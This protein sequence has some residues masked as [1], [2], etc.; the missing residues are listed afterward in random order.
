MRL[1]QALL[2]CLAF[3]F[4]P[5]IALTADPRAGRPASSPEAQAAYQDIQRTL[6]LVPTFL[7]RYP[8]EAIAAAWQE[9]K[10]LQLNPRTALSGRYKELIGLGVSA[11]I[12][13]KF[14]VHFH[15][16]AARLNGA[17]DQEVREA[18]AQASL[19]RQW[20]T[21][22]NGLQIDEA[23]FRDEMRQAFEHTRRAMQ[24]KTAPPPETRITDAQSA[25]D[26]MKRTLGVVPTFFRRFP[27]AAIASAWQAYKA[28]EM[29]PRTALSGKHKELIGLAVSAQVPCKFCTHFHTEAARMNGATDAE[30]GEAVA[31]AGLTRKWSTFLNGIEMDESTFKREVAQIMAHVQRGMRTAAAPR[32]ADLR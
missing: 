26:D 11:Q 24:Q 13:C 30:V 14:C 22:V 4:V 9:M 32:G 19:T 8:Q 2:V 3:L 31:M 25:Y 16:R 7:Q 6:G 29:N 12:P 21:I 23:Q 27:Q 18:L 5:A 10:D 1:R 20:S 28:V 15:T 17:S